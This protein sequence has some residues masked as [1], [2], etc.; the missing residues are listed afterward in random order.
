MKNNS[1]PRR[2]RITVFHLLWVSFVIA[3][4]LLAGRKLALWGK[5]GW[6]AGGLTG[7]LSGVLPL[8]SLW[9][10]AEFY[11]RFR[12]PRPTCRNE[13]CRSDDYE[14]NVVAKEGSWGSENRCKCGDTYLRS[15]SRF[16]LLLPDGSAQPYRLRKPFHNWEPDEYI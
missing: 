4:G 10:L 8:Y 11:C 2:P 16:M 5:V 3:C 1:P 9:L 12:P 6:L 15:G 13:K 14:I 7:I